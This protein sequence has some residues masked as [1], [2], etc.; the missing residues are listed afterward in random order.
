YGKVLI[1]FS[2]ELSKIEKKTGSPEKPLS[3]LGLLSYRSY[4]ADMILEILYQYKGD[5][6]ISEIVDQTAICTEDIVHTLQALDMVKYY[7]GQYILCLSEKNI[8]YH[9]KNERKK[10]IRID[11]SYISWVPPKFQQHQLRFI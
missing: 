9:E 7:K 6:L 3:D 10:R 4:W 8:E 2:Y 5:I 1:Q 11:A